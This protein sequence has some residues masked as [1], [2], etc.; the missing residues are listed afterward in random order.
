MPLMPWTL[1]NASISAKKRTSNASIA[2]K[3]WIKMIWFQLPWTPRSTMKR[4]ALLP[5]FCQHNPLNCKIEVLGALKLCNWD[6]WS[7]S[8]VWSV[9][10]YL[11]RLS[12]IGVLAS[13]PS[14]GCDL[15]LLGFTILLESRYSVLP[16]SHWGCHYLG[17]PDTVYVLFC[18]QDN[19]FLGIGKRTCKSMSHLTGQS[20][21][22][23][24]IFRVTVN[25]ASIINLSRSAARFTWDDKNI[26]IQC[27]INGKY[28]IWQPGSFL[29]YKPVDSLTVRS[30]NLRWV[31]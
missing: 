20:F 2:F 29:V 28:T 6:L 23:W 19:E 27:W 7:P 18:H 11:C 22:H 5:D 10:V 14:G 21:K 24:Q 30:N 9:W 16:I 3:A 8:L 12:P 17:S 25:V 1:L 26:L 31:N 15:S 13:S 4:S